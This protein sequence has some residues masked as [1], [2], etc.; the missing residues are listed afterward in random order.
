VRMTLP[1][2]F[3]GSVTFIVPPAAQEPKVF[4]RARSN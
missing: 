1:A 4:F 2:P 3:D